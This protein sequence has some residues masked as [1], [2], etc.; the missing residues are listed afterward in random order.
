[1]TSNSGL[2]DNI[3]HCTTVSGESWPCFRLD[4][5]AN[6]VAEV[7]QEHCTSQPCIAL[8]ALIQS[9]SALYINISRSIL[10]QVQKYAES[11]H[12][13]HTF[14]I[15]SS[16]ATIANTNGDGTRASTLSTTKNII[17]N[18]TIQCCEQYIF[19]TLRT[20]C[21]ANMHPG[22]C[23]LVF[24]ATHTVLE[25][26]FALKQHINSK[27]EETNLRKCY[28]FTPQLTKK[29]IGGISLITWN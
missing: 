15:Q 20:H 26:L 28:S 27:L 6:A 14:R 7:V 13:I 25:H 23:V 16:G 19:S 12:V 3:Q 2:N 22:F 8:V 10:Y 29:S 24:H 11:W 4:R 17:Q 18:L 21:I 1:M 5:T 9:C